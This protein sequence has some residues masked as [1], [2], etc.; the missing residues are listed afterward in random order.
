MRDE[1]L[2]VHGLLD[3]GVGGAYAGHLRD[4]VQDVGD[5]QRAGTRQLV[6]L[7]VVAV[8]GERRHRHRRD[9]VR[10]DVR[11]FAVPD[12]QGQLP[13]AYAVEED[14]LAEV[15]G[16]PAGPQ[17]RPGQAGGAHGLLA[18]EM[19]APVLVDAGAERSP[20]RSRPGPRAAPAAALRPRPPARRRR[21]SGRAR[22]PAGRCR[23]RRPP[24][25][26]APRWPGPPSR[27]G[28]PRTG[29]PPGSPPPAHG[30]GPPPCGRSCRWS[31]SPG[32]GKV[33]ALRLLSVSWLK[34]RPAPRAPPWLS[35]RE[36]CPPVRSPGG[37]GRGP[38]P[39]R[40][41]APG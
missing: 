23:R 10:V 19:R 29:R 36:G 22:C 9:V 40:G 21:A 30:G 27:T 17:D 5:A 8:L 7:A 4:L 32:R 25:G 12:G 26:R 39:W 35:V 31:R 20:V 16:E 37:Q 6:H 34:R 3:R 14:A 24:P 2:L 13:G 18:V 33:R 15:L 38:C 28:S 41:T 1:A 11:G